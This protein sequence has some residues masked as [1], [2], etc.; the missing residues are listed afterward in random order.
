M[1][2]LNWRPKVIFKVNNNDHTAF[3]SRDYR[4]DKLPL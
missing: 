3:M 4:F 1:G 2:F